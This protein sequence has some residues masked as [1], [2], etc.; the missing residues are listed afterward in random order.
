MK[1]FRQFFHTTPVLFFEE[2]KSIEINFIQKT[3]FQAIC[4]EIIFDP[5]WQ[6]LRINQS[7]PRTEAPDYKRA[8]QLQLLCQFTFANRTHNS[9]S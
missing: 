8:L 9:L 2:R 3:F 7:E 5:T 4:S 6:V 1:N